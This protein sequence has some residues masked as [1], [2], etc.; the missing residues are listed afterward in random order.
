MSHLQNKLVWPVEPYRLG[1]YK[2]GDRI[3]R[4]VFLW[5]VHLGDDVLADAGVPVKA[6]A[7][8]EVVWSEVREGRPDKRNWG[9]LIV[10]RHNQNFQFSIFPTSLKLRGAGNLHTFYSVYGHIGDLRVKV[11]DKVAAGQEIG[12]VAAGNTPEN[13][14]WEKPHLHF[15]IYTGPWNNE[16]PA[17]WWRPEQWR[18]TK[19]KWWQNPREWLQTE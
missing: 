16:V 5:A 4:K 6:A 3:R 14:W 8:G 1:G 2:F 11:G 17:G 15:A 9:G 18:R 13:G 12:R 10:L 7:E 19:L